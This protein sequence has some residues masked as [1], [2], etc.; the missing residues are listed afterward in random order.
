M[1]Y[2][3]AKIDKITNFTEKPGTYILNNP[4][5]AFQHIIMEGNSGNVGN[6]T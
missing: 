4:L 2:I 5:R 1:V 6:L 3:S